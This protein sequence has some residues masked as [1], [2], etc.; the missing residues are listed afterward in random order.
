MMIDRVVHLNNGEQGLVAMVASVCVDNSDLFVANPWWENVLVGD[1]LINFL[2]PRVDGW[3]IAT[4][5][6][7][8]NVVIIISD[9]ESPVRGNMIAAEAKVR[10]D[11]VAFRGRKCREHHIPCTYVCSGVFPLHVGAL[12]TNIWLVFAPW[13]CR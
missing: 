11:I 13:S 7:V 1:S 3:H 8:L 12:E 2:T 6:V 5:K 10:V 9:G 4:G